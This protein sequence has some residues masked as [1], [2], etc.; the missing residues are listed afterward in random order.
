MSLL[1]PYP[2]F[3]QDKECEPLSP[4]APASA[5][6]A[7]GF[8]S[9]SSRVIT[10]WGLKFVVGVA[11]SLLGSGLVNGEAAADEE[12]TGDDAAVE[13]EYEDREPPPL[14]IEAPDPDRGWITGGYYEAGIDAAGARGETDLDIHQNLRL[15]LSPPGSERVRFD[16]WMW[17]HADVDSSQPRWSVLRDINEAW[18]SQIRV[19]VPHLYAEIDDVWGDSTLRIGRQRIRE[20]VAFSRIDGAYFRQ[21]RP[22]WDWY[23]FI[24]AR[25]SLYDERLFRDLI[26]GGG[27]SSQVLPTTRVAVDAYYAQQRRRRSSEVRVNPVRALLGR[28]YPRRVRRRLGDN[29]YTLSVWQDLG[30]NHRLFGQFTLNNGSADELVLDLTGFNLPWDLSYQL[31]YRARLQRL[32]E[33]V[34]DIAYFY[35]VLGPYE[36]FDNLLASVHKPFTERLALTLEAEFHR[37]DGDNVP[38]STNRDYDRYAA[39]LSMTDLGPGL[40]V[41]AGLERWDVSGGESLWTVT[42]EVKKQWNQVDAALGVDFQRYKDVLVQYNPLP[43]AAYQGFVYA[44]PG[45]YPGFAPG[46]RLLDEWKVTTRENVYGAYAR[47]NWRISDRQEFRTRITYEEDDGPQSPYWRLRT[48]YTFRF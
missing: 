41:S 3:P 21:S 34:N 30:L 45:V 4:L 12:V 48:E 5:R 27:V 25:A 36:R 11:L 17:L 47:I 18:D 24:G 29:L 14:M 31:T 38:Y 39:I 33:R 1:A 9:L 28:S 6:K 15:Q 22:D 13:I 7:R 44:T 42:G 2:S 43:F 10:A 19:R 16:G 40:D 35:R 46:V 23:A 20:G 8:R 32:G 37:S 26:S